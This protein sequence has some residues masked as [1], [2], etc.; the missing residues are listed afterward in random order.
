MKITTVS[1]LTISDFWSGIRLHKVA[2]RQGDLDGAC[3]PYSLMMALLLTKVITFSQ[4]KKLWD[5]NLDGRNKFA[6]WTKNFDALV[7]K[8][9]DD[10]DLKKLFSAIQP[11]INTKKAMNLKML[12]LSPSNKNSNLKG[13]SALYMVKEHIENHDM[14]VILVLD[15]SKNSSH[16]VVAVGYQEIRLKSGKETLANILTLDP[17]SSTG[18]TGAWNGVL[19]LGSFNDRKLRY[20]TEDT[21]IV[22]CSI[23]QGIGFATTTA[24]RK[25]KKVMS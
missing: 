11:L 4:A 15:W 23:S 20:M 19:G 18:K 21:E 10:A 24:S 6:K 13:E 1:T 14:P 16:W 3:G 17:G 2:L 7:T 25:I 9:T 12:N 8:G 5:S 22:T